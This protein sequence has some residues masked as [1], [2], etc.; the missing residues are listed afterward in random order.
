MLNSTEELRDLESL[1]LPFG[2]DDDFSL[3]TLL[4][5]FVAKDPHLNPATNTYGHVYVVRFNDSKYLEIAWA[6]GV[7]FTG[8][9]P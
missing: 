6:R 4:L 5:A 1:I 2:G 3:S 7:E 9:V 8:I